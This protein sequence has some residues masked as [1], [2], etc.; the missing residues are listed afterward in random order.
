MN[1]KRLGL[2]PIFKQRRRKGPLIMGGD[3][4]LRCWA[5]ESQRP[6][7]FCTFVC[8][9]FALMFAKTKRG[10]DGPCLK[11]MKRLFSWFLRILKDFASTPDASDG[12]CDQIG[13][14][15]ALWATFQSRWQQWLCPNRPHCQAIFVKVSKSF[16]FLVKSFSGNFYRDLAIFY[17]SHCLDLSDI[18]SLGLIL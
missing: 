16:I 9:K 4:C 15:I 17:W 8:S 6:G 3:S 13:Q 1:K 7:S 11:T 2:N 18:G 12:Q 14:F 10:R 5:F